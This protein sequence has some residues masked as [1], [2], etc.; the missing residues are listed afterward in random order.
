MFGKMH[1]YFESFYS[2]AKA[3]LAKSS[4][5]AALKA[6][7]KRAFA[8]IDSLF[9]QAVAASGKSVACKRGCFFCCYLKVGVKAQEAFV[10]ADFVRSTFTP[11]RIA[12]VKKQA[13]ENWEKIKG[14]DA[15]QHLAAN[16]PCPLLKDG[17]CSVYPV[18]PMACR[19]FHA[20]DVRTCEVSFSH[21]EDLTSPDSQIPDVK[22][23]VAGAIV[24][25][26]AAFAHAEYD[27]IA[28][29]LNPA[30]LQAL[31]NPKCE[32]RWAN[33]KRAFE[34]TMREKDY[35]ETFYDRLKSRTPRSTGQRSTGL[36]QAL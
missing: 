29:D 25:V 16:L 32:R 6:V 11:E 14:M 10:I 33:R 30:L 13:H 18:R 17:A 9:Q 12:E 8:E 1:P 5:A 3:A 22:M 7:Q 23:A 4:G 26:A 31:E 28:Y 21:P 2:G 34:A 15:S 24:G 27:A 35:D 36:G 20:Q 19:Q